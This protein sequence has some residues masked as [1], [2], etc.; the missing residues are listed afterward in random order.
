MNGVFHY[1]IP[2]TKFWL[3]CSPIIWDDNALSTNSNATLFAVE[4]VRYGYN[5]TVNE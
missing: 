2:A 5:S 1:V 3:S 4:K